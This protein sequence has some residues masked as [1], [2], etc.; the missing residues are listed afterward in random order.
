MHLLPEV[1]CHEAAHVA[2]YEIFGSSCR[3]HGPEWA[4]L[5][6]KAGFLP[7]LRIGVSTEESKDRKNETK[8]RSYEH[9]CPVCQFVR[10]ARHPNRR[11]RCADCCAAGL[12]G[13]L[14][15]TVRSRSSR[16]KAGDG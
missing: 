15:I 2:V 4:E 6:R 11:W 1:L 9:R 10:Y 16:S 8:N 7:R 5:V 12:D 3:P 14:L 13:K